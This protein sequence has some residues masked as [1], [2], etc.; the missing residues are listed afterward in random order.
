MK[1]DLSFVMPSL[2]SKIMERIMNL[3]ILKTEQVIQ[4]KKK[5]QKLESSGF[6]FRSA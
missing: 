2:T 6:A 3:S 5:K 1:H 4:F